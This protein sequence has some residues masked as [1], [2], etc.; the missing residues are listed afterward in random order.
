MGISRL[1]GPAKPCCSRNAIPW[2][3]LFSPLCSSSLIQVYK[4]EAA[5]EVTDTKMSCLPFNF[6]KR[7]ASQT[8]SDLEALKTTLLLL[9]YSYISISSTYHQQLQK[10]LSDFVVIIP[11]HEHPCDWLLF[12][13]SQDKAQRDLHFPP[14]FS[15]LLAF[16]QLLCLSSFHVVL[17]IGSIPCVFLKAFL[18]V[19]LKS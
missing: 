2:V 13:F 1:A 18:K 11:Q 6:A 19:F 3:V 8:A 10:Q 16:S 9:K 17:H 4:S 12:S 5:D 15:P 7:P 14:P